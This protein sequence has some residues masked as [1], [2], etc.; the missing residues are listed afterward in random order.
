MWESLLKVCSNLFRMRVSVF[1]FGLVLRFVSSFLLSFVICVR[2]CLN[3]VCVVGLWCISM[4]CLLF[5]FGRWL[6]QLCCISCL[7]VWFSVVWL[8]CECSMS[9]FIGMLLLKV[10]MICNVCY[11]CSFSLRGVSRVVSCCL[12]WWM[13]FVIRYSGFWGSFSVFVLVIGL[14]IFF[15]FFLL[16]WGLQCLGV[17]EF[18]VVLVFFDLFVQCCWIGVV[19]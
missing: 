15:D 9:M 14:V 10:W 13:I 16:G 2:V 5:G 4:V 6:I 19:E 3:I 18:V 1:F 7:M 12:C 11:L 17:V 8:V